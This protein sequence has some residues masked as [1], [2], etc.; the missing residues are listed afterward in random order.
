MAPSLH[1]SR[2]LAA[3]Q[4]SLRSTD[5][6][7][8][9]VWSIGNPHL[10]IQFERRVGAKLT[11]DSWVDVAS[12]DTTLNPLQDVT[13]RG[14]RVPADGT[15]ALFRVGNIKFESDASGTLVLLFLCC[16]PY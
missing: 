15:G 13:T 14:F 9:A 16:I 3:A 4:L 2:W 10:N 8:L 1:C 12:L 6:K 11:L 5:V 7:D